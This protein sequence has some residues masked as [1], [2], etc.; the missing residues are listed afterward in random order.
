MRFRWIA[1][2]LVT[3]L[4]IGLVLGI[5]IYPLLFRTTSTTTQTVTMTAALSVPKC[6]RTKWMIG[7]T[8]T[9]TAIRGVVVLPPHGFSGWIQGEYYYN[10]WT[11]DYSKVYPLFWSGTISGEIRLNVSLPV[12]IYTAHGFLNQAHAISMFSVNDQDLGQP[13]LFFGNPNDVPISVTYSI[14]GTGDLRYS[15]TEPICQ[16]EG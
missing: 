5:T 6:L 4:L 8:T 3:G 15:P 16:I 13:I 9:W 7:N 1:V 14:Y 11:N 12:D 2:F 10:G